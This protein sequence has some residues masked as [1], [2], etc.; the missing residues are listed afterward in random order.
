MRPIFLIEP[1]HSFRQQ[2]AAN[3]L[4]ANMVAWMHSFM[5]LSFSMYEARMFLA[6]YD[7]CVD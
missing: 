4:I 3:T 2:R 1:L 7:R 5:V 6:V